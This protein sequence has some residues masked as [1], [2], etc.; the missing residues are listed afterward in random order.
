MRTHG[1]IEVFHFNFADF[2]DFG[3]TGPGLI[4]AK[5]KSEFTNKKPTLRIIPNTIYRALHCTQ[6]SESIS[7]AI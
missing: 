2:A 4:K 6:S 5:L 1:A 7:K 3:G